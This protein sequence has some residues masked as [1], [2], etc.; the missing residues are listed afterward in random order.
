MPLGELH[1]IGPGTS[2]HPTGGPFRVAVGRA[3]A[4]AG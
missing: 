4:R 3:A 1:G 2:V